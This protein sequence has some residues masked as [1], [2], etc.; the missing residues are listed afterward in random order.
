MHDTLGHELSF[1]SCLHSSQPPR[2]RLNEGILDTR[3]LSSVLDKAAP[4][5]LRGPPAVLAKERHLPS[6]IGLYP[7]LGDTD[8]TSSVHLKCHL[9]VY[10]KCC[11][12][13]LQSQIMRLI[14][15]IF[16]STCR[17]SHNK[18]HSSHCMR[19]SLGDLV[20]VVTEHTSATCEQT[21]GYLRIP[22][23][24]SH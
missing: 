3:F 21:T 8:N 19:R 17:Y 16:C 9:R 5:A 6:R 22:I 1:Y 11:S 15:L 12:V 4:L 20:M 10:L 2:S 7:E 24:R 18:D 14:T 13:Y 23:E